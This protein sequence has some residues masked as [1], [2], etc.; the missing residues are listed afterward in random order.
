LT[1]DQIIE[2]VARDHNVSKQVIVGRSRL[3]SIALAR[4]IAM[5]Q[6]VE[7]CG[8]SYPQVGRIFDNRDHT[9]IMHAY[10]KVKGLIVDGKLE[11]GDNR[12]MEIVDSLSIEDNFKNGS[13]MALSRL[14]RY[15][16]EDYFSAILDINTM[17][18]N[19]GY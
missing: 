11:V 16:K 14:N 9:T 5:Y 8:Y 2:E 4:A 17:L 15:L 3:K 12:E 7:R 6:V 13:A 10:Q 18:K 19:R 1:P